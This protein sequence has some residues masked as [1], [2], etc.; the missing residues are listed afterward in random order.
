MP[1]FAQHVATPADHAGR[2]HV[3]ALPAGR[4]IVSRQE[5]PESLHRVAGRVSGTLGM[6]IA[7]VESFLSAPARGAA[8]PR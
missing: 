6:D 5:T 2:L 7:L 3:S 8:A 1:V 4:R